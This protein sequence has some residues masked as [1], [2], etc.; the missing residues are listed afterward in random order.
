LHRGKVASRRI[1]CAATFSQLS[2]DNSLRKAPIIKVAIASPGDL[3]DVRDMIP[4]IFTRWNNI[5]SHAYLL[6]TMWEGATPELGDHP[7]QV[8]N[9]QI[10]DESDL[11]IAMFWTRVGTP[12][13]AARSGTIEEIQRFVRRQG[14]SRTMLYFCTRPSNQA[15][16]NQDLTEL[17]ALQSFRREMQSQ[18]LYY[19]FESPEGFEI[20]IY[21]HLETK[22]SELLQGK[23]GPVVAIDSEKNGAADP[24]LRQPIEFGARLSEIAAGFASRMQEFNSIRGSNNDKFLDFG[25]HVLKSVAS[26][27]DRYLGFSGHNLASETVHRIDRICTKVKTLASDTVDRKAAFSKFWPKAT[28][29]SDELLAESRYLGDSI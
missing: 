23:L 28:E 14:G 12:T 1:I 5:H 25:V 27:V 24:R 29:L 18:G 9:R 6:A 20:A 10:I 11:L 19:E 26:G 7:Q 13:P 3:T 16:L 17:A 22:V 2:E 21:R 8:L 15:P 4:R